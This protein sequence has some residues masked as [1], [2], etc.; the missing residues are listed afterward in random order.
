MKKQSKKKQTSS[1]RSIKNWNDL[2]FWNSKVKTELEH[3]ITLREYK[4]VQVYPPRQ[5]RLLAYTATKFEDVKC[6]ILGQDPYHT[7][8]TAHGLAFSVRDTDIAPPPSLRNI[9][10]EYQSD[11]GYPK[12]SHACLYPWA[13]RGVLLL[14][15]VLTVESNR[16]NA[17]AGWGWEYLCIETIQALSSQQERGVAFCL[18]GKAAQE[19][20]G[21]I[22]AERHLIIEASHPS[23]YSYTKGFKGH[24][25]FTRVNEFLTEPIDW[26]L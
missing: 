12:P 16:P 1:R 3:K 26:R 13:I 22:N 18:W 7:K 24:K 5:H 8:G 11:L 20:K 4:G 9:L 17:H 14:N 6:V 15:T 23:P 19:Y 10:N 21:L 2:I 25:P